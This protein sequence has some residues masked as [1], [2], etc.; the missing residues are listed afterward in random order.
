MG[1]KKKSAINHRMR[2][3]IKKLSW[4]ELCKELEKNALDSTGIEKLCEEILRC[5]KL[6][7]KR[8]SPDASRARSAFIMELYT[9]TERL[10]GVD[11][12]MQA[13]GLIESFDVIDEGYRRVY[14]R[15]SACLIDNDSPDAR[16]SAVLNRLA[17]EYDDISTK[18]LQNAPTDAALL[19]HFGA[20]YETT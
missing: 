4:S 15:F 1:R 6:V 19:T 16:I 7:A 11:A 2:S 8:P 9:F 18:M 14:D 17:I 20:V 3:A 13:M 5:S 12:A 10:I